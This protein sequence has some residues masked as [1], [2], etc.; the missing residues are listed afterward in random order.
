MNYPLYLHDETIEVEIDVAYNASYR[1]AQ[2]SGPP[3]DCYPDE[4]ELEVT[5]FTVVSATL[6][7][8]DALN[9]TADELTAAF[10]KEQGRIIAACWEDFHRGN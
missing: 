6:L 5:G 3:E 10:Q 1:P 7:D 8:G 9:F 4:S 2:I